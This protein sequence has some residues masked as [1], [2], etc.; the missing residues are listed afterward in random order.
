[1]RS[2]R[3]SPF[4]SL[5]RIGDQKSRSSRT[6]GRLLRG[7][8]CSFWTFLREQRPSTQETANWP[9]L[10]LR[11]RCS[12]FHGDMHK[13]SDFL[14]SQMEK[15]PRRDT[16]LPSVWAWPVLGDRLK[17]PLDYVTVARRWWASASRS[18][19]VHNSQNVSRDCSPL[20]AGGKLLL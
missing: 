8:T 10:S 6:L 16:A 19:R 9:F 4:R 17:F 2:Y 11:A 14:A 5:Q 1:V 7:L 13:F 15:R 18:A 12:R 3:S 20:F